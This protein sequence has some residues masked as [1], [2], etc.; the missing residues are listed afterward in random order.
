MWLNLPFIKRRRYQMDSPDPDL[1]T[2]KNIYQRVG[3]DGVD[4]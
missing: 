2:K 1:P 3:T 4:I